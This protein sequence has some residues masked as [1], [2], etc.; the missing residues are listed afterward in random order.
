MYSLVVVGVGGTGSNLAT[1]LAQYAINEKK[2]KEIILIDEDIVES[3]NFRNQKFTERDVN[4]NKARVLA[5]RFKK[6]GINISYIDR[7]IKSKDNIKNIIKNISN[8]V[9]LIGCVDNVPARKYMHDCFYDDEIETLIYI[10]TGN[11]DKEHCGQTV[12]GA[13]YN[14]KVI[15]PPVGD[16]Y[17]QIL[18]EEIKEE[19]KEDKYKCSAIEEHPQSFA[20]NVLSAT[21]TFMMVN[22]IVS[23]GKV[24]KAYVRFNADYVSIK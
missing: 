17:P 6:L 22:N 21:T 5:T 9:I 11:G 23:L 2:V 14:G 19:K 10:D 1:F 12:V 7:Y 3:K 16:I 13:K 24:K 4:K 8:D 18:V 15:R 20:V